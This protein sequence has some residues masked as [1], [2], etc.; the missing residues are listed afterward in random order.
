[1][2]QFGASL[3]DDV[4]KIQGVEPA[5][6]TTSEYAPNF[7]SLATNQA[8][9][10]LRATHASSSTTVPLAHVMKLE[11]Q[12]PKLLQ[13]VRPWIQHVIEKFMTRVEKRMKK[14]MDHKVQSIH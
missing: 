6:T 3:V 14:I 11:A 7:H 1:M 12:M 9:I 5:S 4:E 8:P 10:S 2:P 13:H